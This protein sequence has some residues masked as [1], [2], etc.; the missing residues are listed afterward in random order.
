MKPSKPT[1]S[2]V[3]LNG[4][5]LIL[6]VR[7]TRANDHIGRHLSPFL[8]ALTV[9]SIPNLRTFITFPTK[10]AKVGRGMSVMN[11]GTTTTYWVVMSVSVH[12]HSQRLAKFSYLSVFNRSITITRTSKKTFYGGDHG[13][14][15]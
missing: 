2:I 15:R 9:I 10:R 14:S 7:L 3:N 8:Q 1:Y 6:Q 13:Y 5:M 4:T 11:S 12:P